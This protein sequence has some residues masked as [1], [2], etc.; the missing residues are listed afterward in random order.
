LVKRCDLWGIF[1][2]DF[3]N[4][5]LYTMFYYIQIIRQFGYFKE[6]LLTREKTQ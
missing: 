2:T 4:Y 1:S 3:L 6:A 5:A